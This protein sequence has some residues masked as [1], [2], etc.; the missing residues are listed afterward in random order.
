MN[1]IPFNAV[2]A[3]DESQSFRGW[4]VEGSRNVYILSLYGK[5]TPCQDDD[6]SQ[7]FIHRIN[8]LCIRRRIIG[9][10]IILLQIYRFYSYSQ[11]NSK[12][13]E[14]SQMPFF[15]FVY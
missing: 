2:V 11:K 14:I 9:F 7:S 12:G 15:N 8:L 3:I 10:V 6:E 1:G 13:K 5:Q 4:F